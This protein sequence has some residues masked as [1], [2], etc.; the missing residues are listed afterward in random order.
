LIREGDNTD[1]DEG[2]MD[3]LATEEEAINLATVGAA[4]A[5][6]LNVVLFE[7]DV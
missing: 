1:E 7:E 2:D 5:V 6:I 4:D 3:E